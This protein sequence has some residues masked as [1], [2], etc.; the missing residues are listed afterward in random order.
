MKLRTDLL[1]ALGTDG[2][3]YIVFRRT[4]TFSVKTAD[5][6]LKKQREPKFYLGNG[7]LLECADGYDTFK[8]PGGELMLRLTSL[9]IPG[10]P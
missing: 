5:G 3:R 9:E 10:T 6:I 1:R 8:T 4:R 7:D 2:Q